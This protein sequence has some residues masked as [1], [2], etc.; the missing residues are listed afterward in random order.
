MAQGSLKRVR[1]GWLAKSIEA[2]KQT[3]ERDRAWFAAVRANWIDHDRADAIL[4]LPSTLEGG[5]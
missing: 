3:S 1:P 4:S 5:E 2:A